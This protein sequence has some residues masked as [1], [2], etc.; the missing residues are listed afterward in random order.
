MDLLSTSKPPSKSPS[1]HRIW[2]SISN[3]R[4]TCR[5]KTKTTEATEFHRE[6][7]CVTLCPLW[8]KVLRVLSRNPAPDHKRLATASPLL[9]LQRRIN[10]WI[11]ADLVVWPLRPSL[12]RKIRR[13]DPRNPALPHHNFP[14]DIPID[15]HGSAAQPVLPFIR[16][17]QRR[18]QL[19]LQ[20]LQRDLLLQ[21]AKGHFIHA[22]PAQVEA[23]NLL[24]RV[25]VLI[26]LRRLEGIQVKRS[27]LRFHHLARP[28]VARGQ[29][30]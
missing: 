24:F 17:S 22:N 30:V 8:L 5:E 3:P 27:R 26:P 9:L 15:R 28:L 10:R 23:Q 16:R 29:P 11:R 13:I 4:I 1:A 14:K 25:P 2:A 20:R 6:T 12:Y 7:L 21:L 18:R 19:H